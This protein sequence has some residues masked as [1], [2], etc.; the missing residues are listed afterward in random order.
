MTMQPDPKPKASWLPD[1]SK[2][3]WR[4]LLLA[5]LLLN[6]AVAGAVIGGRWHHR[7]GPGGQPGF[8][9]FAPGRFFMSLGADRRRELADML[10]GAR[11]EFD[12]LRQRNAALAGQVAAELEK[13]DFDAAKLAALIDGFTTGPDSMAAKGGMVLKNFYAKLTPEER[14]ALAK[15]IRERLARKE[16]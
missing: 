5:S 11:P 3:F 12:N 8:Q 15:S 14:V 7:D 4:F 6:L 13:S 1:T 16:P 9:Q 10:R 2:G